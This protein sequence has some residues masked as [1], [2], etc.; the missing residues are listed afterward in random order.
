MPKVSVLLSNYNGD[1]H[2]DESISSVL[3]QTY[4]DFEFIIVDDASTD[5]SRKVIENYH[6]KRIKKYY[7]EKNRNIAYSLNLALS[8]ASGEYIARIDSDDAWELNKLEIQVQ[9]MDNHPE[10]GACFTKVNIIDAYSN[11]ANDV[12]GE[13]FQ[14]FNNAENRS[15][16][17]WLRFFFYQGNC[18]CH[19]S[20]VIRRSALER[21]GEYYHLAYV[22]AEDYELWTRI[23]MKYPIHILEEKLVRYRWEETVN[24]ISGKTDGRIYA[25]PNI[26][27]LTRK[28]IMDN[29]R[30][31]DFV[32]YFKEDFINPESESQEELE[33][34]KA[35]ILLRCS[36]DNANFLGL[37]KYEELLDNEKMLKVLEEKMEF[38]LSEYYKEYR[39][40]NFDLLGELEKAKGDI[41]H[42][43]AD[44]EEKQKAIEN[45]QREVEQL[46]FL[47]DEVMSSTS[48]KVTSPLRRVTRTLKRRK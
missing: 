34:E 10:C 4:K 47:V 2:L 25:F 36:G 30:N 27:M 42:L 35:H 26:M 45:K 5:S 28:K 11:I 21:I 6:D 16:K 33:C 44:V 7:A 12:Y 43:K 48:W 8:M 41:R 17:E 19:P 9:Y 20:V 46:Q 15:Q 39:T 29:I 22:P 24:K 32:R 38:S 40:R 31:E 18:L 1:K 14:L 23:V 3:S 13:Y 37:E